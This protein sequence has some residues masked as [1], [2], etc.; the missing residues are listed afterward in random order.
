MK[1]SNTS[2]ILLM[3]VVVVV[4]LC[5][6]LI[7]E[8]LCYYNEGKIG[9][10]ELSYIGTIT[11]GG[12][13]LFG[14]ILTIIITIEI[15]KADVRQRDSERKE[16]LS[17][18]YKPVLQIEE[19]DV[20]YRS[21]KREEPVYDYSDEEG[22]HIV[23]I[24]TWTEHIFYIKLKLKNCGRGEILR[25][26]V[27]CNEDDGYLELEY[28][29]DFEAVFQGDTVVFEFSFM[30]KNFEEMVEGFYDKCVLINI[31]YYDCVEKEG[32]IQVPLYISNSPPIYSYNEVI[33]EVEKEAENTLG[34]RLGA[35][36]R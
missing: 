25:G 1:K 11:G 27:A 13:T 18:E 14:V 3:L 21:Y 30:V 32:K 12:L 8:G 6:I 19:K 26:H 4:V 22:F 7:Y 10:D 31:H 5:A 28:R 29:K 16:N 15:H 35:I 17:I 23:D 33:G 9:G 2:K 36:I 24:E 34:Y 20:I